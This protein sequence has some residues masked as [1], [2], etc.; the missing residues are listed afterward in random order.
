MPEALIFGERGI[1]G[2][3]KAPCDRITHA[4]LVQRAIQ[5]LLGAG[6]CSIA[7]SEF[8]TSAGEAPDAIGFK[9]RWSVVVE[10]KVSRQDF[11]ADR[12]KCH[13]RNPG[14]AMGAQRYFMVPAGLIDATDVPDKWGLLH[15]HSRHVRIIRNSDGFPDRGYIREIAFLVS[16]LRRVEIRAVAEHR[17]NGNTTWPMD[18]L[19]QWIKGPRS[20]EPR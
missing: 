4:D 19:N 14:M 15:V 3:V 16:M 11:L 5:W 2:E 9:A 8:S 1:G 13:R 20:G 12:H 18:F 7:F 17:K 6:G 10:C